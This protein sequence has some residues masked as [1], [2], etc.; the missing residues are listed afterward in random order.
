M[1]PA[2]SPVDEQG[3]E[4]LEGG[5]G[6]LAQSCPAIAEPVVEGGLADDEPFEKVV[7]IQGQRPAQLLGI[8]AAGEALEVSDV[9][10]T[11]PVVEA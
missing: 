3:G 7:S 1:R 5:A 6:V 4:A 8:V 10:L 11:E 2:A 9:D